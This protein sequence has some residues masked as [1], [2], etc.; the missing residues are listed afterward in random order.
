[1]RILV[2]GAGGVGGALVPIAKRR[3]F[4]EAVVVADYDRDRAGKVVDR[5]DDPRFRA[6]QVNAS[7]S[8]ALRG[9]IVRLCAVVLDLDDDRGVPEP[10]AHLGEGPWLV[11]DRTLQRARDVHLPRWHRTGGLRQ[12]RARGGR[13]DPALGA[14]QPGHLQIRPR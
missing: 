5:A 2:V 11:H 1:M 10:A 9:L 4:F 14:G 8:K 12:R 13:P 3:S 7:D 6:A